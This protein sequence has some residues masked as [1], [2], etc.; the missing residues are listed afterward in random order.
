[1][2][3]V[4]TIGLVVMDRLTKNVDCPKAREAPSPCVH[5]NGS[6][7]LG[8]DSSFF[9]IGTQHYGC[10]FRE[11]HDALL[12]TLPTQQY[13]RWPLDRNRLI[14]HPCGEAVAKQVGATIRC[15]YSCT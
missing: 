3:L 2:D 14:D 12:G 9:E 5:E 11:G 8:G 4:P 6:F 15:L 13:L 10:I 7:W 1:I